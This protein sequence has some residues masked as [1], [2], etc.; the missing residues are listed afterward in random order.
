MGLCRGSP[1]WRQAAG[2]A[3]TVSLEA[4]KWNEWSL[5]LSLEGCCMTPRQW[6]EGCCRVS[7]QWKDIGDR[8]VAISTYKTYNL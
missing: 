7:R 1:S 3:I 6:I 2:P 4:R 5:Y 8:P